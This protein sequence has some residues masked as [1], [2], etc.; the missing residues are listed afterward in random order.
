MQLTDEK[1]NDKI[2]IALEKQK[3]FKR[4]KIKKL[5]TKAKR[6]VILTELCQTKQRTQ[7][8]DK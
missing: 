1:Q 4:E 7:N 3:S 5:L 8:I 2:K 6:Y